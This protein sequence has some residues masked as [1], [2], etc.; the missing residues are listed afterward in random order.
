MTITEIYEEYKFLDSLLPDKEWSPD[1]TLS[2][3]LYDLWQTVKIAAQKEDK[4]EA[5]KMK[6]LM[7]ILAWYHRMSYPTE[8]FAYYRC[9]VCN[10][11]WWEGQ[12]ERHS[13]YNKCWIPKLHNA[14]RQQNEVKEKTMSEELR[15]NRVNLDAAFR[16]LRDVCLG[17]RDWVLSN[18]PC[19]DYDPYLTIER[20]LSDARQM[21]EQL[22]ILETGKVHQ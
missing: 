7:E 19:P 13:F 5:V 22:E 18:P 15:R 1:T 6:L 2:S 8:R 11:T 20:A 4:G 16:A 3:I 10:L 9:P 14:V 17:K 12:T 21:L